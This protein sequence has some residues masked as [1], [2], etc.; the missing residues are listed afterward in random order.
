[1]FDPIIRGM[2]QGK[3]TTAAEKV[4]NAPPTHPIESYA[5]AFAAEGYPDFAVRE[6]EAGLQACLM[7]SLDWTLLR[8]YHFDVFEWYLADFDLWVKVRFLIND[9][10]EVASV[11]IPIEPEVE[12]VVF[13]R[14]P[15]EIPE[16]V[17]AQLLGDY[18]LPFAGLRL[19]FTKRDDKFYVTQTGGNAEEVTPYKLDEGLVGFRSKR[20]RFDFV[21]EDGVI[22]KV[23]IKAP[24][25]TF[26]APRNIVGDP[27]GG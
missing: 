11:S 8:H 19:T 18:L 12:N 6:T 21:R 9:N 4:E 24:G 5:G 7:G 14:K 17:V 1:M 15:V 3:K 20:T 22:G 26:E 27:V 10:G 23:L 13:E 16:D 25:V 2:A